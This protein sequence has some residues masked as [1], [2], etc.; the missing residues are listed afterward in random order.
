MAKSQESELSHGTKPGDSIS[1]DSLRVECRKPP[2]R[3]STFRM[4]EQHHGYVAHA[5]MNARAI[6]ERGYTN[7]RK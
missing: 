4:S 7:V 6:V 5:R 1:G 2:Q 3:W